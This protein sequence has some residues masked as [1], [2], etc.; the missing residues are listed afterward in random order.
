MVWGAQSKFDAVGGIHETCHES[1]MMVPWPQDE[2]IHKK[3]FKIAGSIPAVNY[4]KVPK[5]KALGLTGRFLYLQVG[6]SRHNWAV[7]EATGNPAAAVHVTYHVSS[8]P[9]YAQAVC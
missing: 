5:A 4:L 8:K 3:V 6:M 1:L 9:S 7:S 2:V